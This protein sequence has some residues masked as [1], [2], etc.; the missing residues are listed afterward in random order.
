M[1]VTM[2]LQTRQAVFYG[3]ARVKYNQAFSFCQILHLPPIR[4]Q[5]T[6]MA[7]QVTVPASAEA[8]AIDT[9]RGDG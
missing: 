5:S 3:V 8:A 1:V 2:T 7:E 4:S 6:N 9:G